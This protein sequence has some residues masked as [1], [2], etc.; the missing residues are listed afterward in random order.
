MKPSTRVGHK[1]SWNYRALMAVLPPAQTS[2]MVTPP[3][4]NL[5]IN[6]PFARSPYFCLLKIGL[7]LFKH[8]N[9]PLKTEKNSGWAPSV[10]A[11]K[12]LKKMFKHFPKAVALRIKMYAVCL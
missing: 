7:Q 12:F 8:S 3:K 4:E 6:G 11:T 2:L 10:S 1:A 5:Y 9:K